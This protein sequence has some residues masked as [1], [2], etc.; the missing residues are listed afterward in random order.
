MSQLEPLPGPTVLTDLKQEGSFQASG[1]NKSSSFLS[2]DSLQNHVNSWLARAQKSLE[3][4]DVDQFVDL[5]SDDGYW[6]DI[7]TI[8][9]DFNSL[10]KGSIK[11]YLDQHKLSLPSLKNLKLDRPDQLKQTAD[12]LVQ[13]FIKFETDLYRG[14]GLLKLYSK[15]TGIPSSSP[16][17]ALLFFTQV[18][19]VK[20]HEENLLF[21]R[22]LGVPDVRSSEQRPLNWLEERVRS[23]ERYK[24]G[25]DPT[26]LIIGGGQ[27][28]LS[29]AARL[30]VLGIDSLVV[31]KSVRLGDC[32][33][34]RYHSLCLHDPVWADHLA[35]MP[36]PSTWPV[37]TPKDKLANWF[38]H[39]AESMELD[40]WL[41][42]RLVPGAEY[43]T[44]DGRW[45]VDIELS[46]GEGRSARTIRLHPRYLVL[47][48]GLNG[49]PRWP[50]NIAN[51]EAY[52]GTAM[53]SSQFK[54]GQQW[55]GKHAVIVGACNSA[56]DIAAEL[57]Q[58]GAAEVTMVQ[59]SRTFVMSSKHGIPALMEGLYEE[60]GI[61]TEDADRIFTSLPI[62]LL[63][64]THIKLQE[65]IAKLD[66]D[67]L[68]SLENV[69]FKLDPYPAGMLIKYF[70][71]GGGY[72]I[73]VG[74]SELIASK[75]IKLKQ[76]KE[77]ASLTEHGLQF[78]DGEEID[79]D[80]IVFATGYQSI[81]KTIAKM[82]SHQVA[83]R[84]GP[85]WGKDN[86]GEIPGTWRLFGQPGLW[87]MCGNFFQARCF[88]KHLATQILLQELQ[89]YEKNW[90]GRAQDKL[91]VDP[92]D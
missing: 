40:V 8:E 92:Q 89:I 7:L 27:N 78:E 22:P 47:A 20:G 88:S 57:Y 59:R 41:Q 32:W 77:V 18:W 87:L 1:N 76:G 19:E 29:L 49:A 58:S 17:K 15:D 25:V 31:E 35:Y 85:V 83:N 66:R 45:T 61:A 16:S 63:E 55:R 70:R 80:L 54:S 6:R 51:F 42:A 84:L 53:H 37:Y 21:R 28:G 46:G 23:S 4:K 44:E 68:Q 38:E 69:G 33:R 30:K 36:Y 71:R 90:P 26:V 74:C 9:L 14:N 39:Y 79:A 43:D 62:N 24:Q 13:S 50:N 12:G 91:P 86:Q 3:E 56:H 5:F 82:I 52:S 60:G 48:T 73:D 11:P 72:Y 65:K 81:R 10:A 67:L 34:S 2:S 75:R 64:K